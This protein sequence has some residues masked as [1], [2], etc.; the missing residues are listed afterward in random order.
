[1]KII[2][3]N[4]SQPLAKN[5]RLVLIVTE[6]QA[7]DGWMDGSRF[8]TKQTQAARGDGHS[9]LHRTRQRGQ[10]KA[11]CCPRAS[12]FPCPH[13]AE[14]SHGTAAACCERGLGPPV[15]TG[16]GSRALPWQWLLRGRG[17][18]P[19]SQGSAQASLR[20]RDAGN[21]MLA[22]ASSPEEHMRFVCDNRGISKG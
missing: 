14:R 15:P 2:S 9:C 4:W 1:M 3:S 8:T 5:S 6:T 22:S 17:P 11:P 18:E 12:T 7:R 21:W 19:S 20:E 13:V 10:E 16:L